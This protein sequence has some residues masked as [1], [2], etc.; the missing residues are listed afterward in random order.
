MCKIPEYIYIETYALYNVLILPDSLVT[1]HITHTHSV[2]HIKVGTGGKDAVSIGMIVKGVLN[3]TYHI[4]WVN[5]SIQIQ[6]FGESHSVCVCV[7]VCV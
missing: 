3:C 2:Y 1:S 5:K 4:C 7:C 6:H